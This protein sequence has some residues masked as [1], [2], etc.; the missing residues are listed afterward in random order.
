MAKPAPA[1][2]EIQA[3]VESLK[4]GQVNFSSI[5]VAALQ[6]DIRSL[7]KVRA[8]DAYMLEG[9]LNAK[10]MKLDEALIA[11][12]KSIEISSDPLY[13][14]NF[15]TSLVKLNQFE[16]GARC[17]DKA[18]ESGYINTISVRG[19]VWINAALLRFRRAKEIIDKYGSSEVFDREMDPSDYYY[20][21]KKRIPIFLDFSN[22]YNV[23]LDQMEL[24]GQHAAVVLSQL[25]CVVRLS[26]ID[27]C[28][29][30]GSPFISVAFFVNESPER[31]H[32]LNMQLVDRVASDERV[33][34]WD[35]VIPE[36][37]VLPDEAMYL[38]E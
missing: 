34:C 38:V 15:A 26:S 21:L 25:T 2:N 28:D 31:V 6:R 30:Y 19:G 1:S 7:R 8:A 24:I 20:E 4:V 3:R 13:L 10:A 33:E 37:K 35:R 14:S 9:I 22:K 17:R 18:I 32:E 5:E 11:H 27:M 29:F 16:E 12:K 23:S 36:L